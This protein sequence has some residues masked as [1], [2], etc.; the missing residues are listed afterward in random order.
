MRAMRAVLLLVLVA[1]CDKKEDDP[2]VVEGQVIVEG[3]NQP[4]AGAQVQ[5]WQQR[6]TGL[7]GGYEPIGSSY[8]SDAQGRFSFPVETQA[9]SNYILRAE[10]EPGYRT[11]WGYQV[12]VQIGRR[13][14]A[15]RLPVQPPAWVRLQLVDEAPKSAILLTMTGY[16]GSHESF[17]Y[18]RDTTLIRPVMAGLSLTITC[19]IDE[20]G[21]SRIAR[22]PVQVAAMDTVSVRITF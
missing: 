9:N 6:G 14:S 15:L 2:T 13:N 17:R 1:S 12:P 5:A 11:D 19:F 22:Y 7:S 8:V 16:G 18:P 4:L 10:K 20:Q 3:T 21:Q